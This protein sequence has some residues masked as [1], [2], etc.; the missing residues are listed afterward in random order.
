M[1]DEIMIISFLHNFLL[2]HHRKERFLRLIFYEIPIA[3]TRRDYR[4]S[5]RP[6]FFPS[7]RLSFFPSLYLSVHLLYYSPFVFSL[8]YFREILLI[9]LLYSLYISKLKLSHKGYVAQ[10]L[11]AKFVQYFQDILIE[12]FRTWVIMIIAFTLSKMSKYPERS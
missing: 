10:T 8:F 5:L 3:R 6:S 4:F 9:L 11:S 2:K 1:H 12:S 7:L